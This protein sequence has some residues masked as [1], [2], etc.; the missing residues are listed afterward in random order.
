MNRHGYVAHPLG[1]GEDREKGR[2]SVCDLLTRI[3]EDAVSQA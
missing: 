3:K 2:L 1:G